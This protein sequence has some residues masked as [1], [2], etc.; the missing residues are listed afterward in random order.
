MTSSIARKLVF[1]RTICPL[2][3]LLELASSIHPREPECHP[4]P[5]VVAN[6]AASP[7]H[8]ELIP[9]DGNNGGPERA[10]ML[11][12]LPPGT[13][14]PVWLLEGG[15]EISGV[16]IDGASQ[17]PLRARLT[18]GSVAALCG[19]G[20]FRGEATH[21]QIWAPRSPGSSDTPEKPVR[22]PRL[23]IAR[24]IGYRSSGWRG[25][26]CGEIPTAVLPVKLLVDDE[27]PAARRFWEARLRRRIE[28]ANRILGEFFPFRLEVVAV[29]S[30]ES[31]DG[32]TTLEAGYRQFAAA[33][34]P[35]PGALA[36]GFASQWSAAKSPGPLGTCSGPLSRHILLREHGPEIT[37]TERL[38]MLLHELGH[39][40]GAGHVEDPQSIMRPKLDDRRARDR[41][42]S[43]GFDPF[44]TI[45]VNL[46]I[47][48]LLAGRRQVDEFSDL[49]IHRLTYFYRWMS[50]DEGSDETAKI[51]ADR[52]GELLARRTA[53]LS[54]A[55][56]GV[57]P[58]QQD[59]AE[60]R[61]PSGAHSGGSSRESSSDHRE[62]TL[63]GGRSVALSPSGTPPGGGSTAAPQVGRSEAQL[64]RPAAGGSPRAGSKDNNFSE[65]TNDRMESHP[66]PP[67]AGSSLEAARWVLGTVVRQWPGAAADLTDRSRPIGDQTLERL[68]RQAAKAAS[69]MPTEESRR[70][71]AFLL[72]LGILV[73]DSELLRQQPA[74][75]NLWQQLEDA[76]QRAE[77]LKR[78]PLP[79]IEGRHD[80]AQHFGVSAALTEILGPGPTRS[81]GL[82]KEWRD[83]QGDSG[84][85]FT[86]LA[87]D[88]AGVAF[89]EAVRSGDV[90]L[91]DLS[92]EFT[93][94]EY[95]PRLSGYDE[96]IPL[97]R[98]I[99]EY[100]G[101]LGQRTQATMREIEAAIKA[102][103]GYAGPRAPS[104]PDRR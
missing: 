33:V 61:A 11:V 70:R 52:F 75:G 91:E 76:T 101:F 85:S 67:S 30:W 65:K 35:R 26:G 95:V 51:L 13:I 15:C 24:S 74:L 60:P 6:L 31:D 36:I 53:G 92:R 10:P 54:D 40:L 103:P 20:H 98:F 39:V 48:E 104:P 2:V 77:R 73:D 17:P 27:E 32:L 46:F 14:L 7:I 45:V 59:T 9:P 18:P 64:S 4:H 94:P 22:I 89:A 82:A 72:A 43:L 79:T 99:G 78:I 84:F 90:T 37:E 58:S 66:A 55:L 63:S 23:E 71:A 3:L 42:F 34:D 69:S 41:Q 49:G 25:F 81:L 56:A 44:N 12:E 29:E 38:E 28:A 1:A 100:G 62:T 96:G 88:Y 21:F 97:G 57:V 86:D 19:P 8:V 80:W 50:A 102:L 16:A 5:A 87:A 93:I 47:A 83:A 68:V